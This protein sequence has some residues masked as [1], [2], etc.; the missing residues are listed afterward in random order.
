MS[1]AVIQYDFHRALVFASGTLLVIGLIMVGSASI[2][3]ADG[4]LNQ[5]LLD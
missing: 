2:S 5:P 1:K 4:K 3:I